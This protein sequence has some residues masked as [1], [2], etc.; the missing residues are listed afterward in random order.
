MFKKRVLAKRGT[1]KEIDM[2]MRTL[3]SIAMPFMRESGEPALVMNKQIGGTFREAQ[4]GHGKVLYG[5]PCARCGVYYAA[6]LAICPV[7]NS[8]ERVFPKIK[9]PAWPVSVPP[10]RADKLPQED[11]LGGL[12][13]INRVLLSKQF[14]PATTFT[15]TEA[16]PAPA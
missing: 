15:I 4:T 9:S 6:E 11:N 7:C 14:Q 16:I 13:T 8:P 5:L 12:A 10:A 1:F 2:R 3:L